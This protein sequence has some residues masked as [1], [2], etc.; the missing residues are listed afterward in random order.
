MSLFGGNQENLF[1]SK[2]GKGPRLPQPRQVVNL[3]TTGD[4]SH[5]GT[6]IRNAEEAAG[7]LSFL[8]RKGAEEAT[9]SGRRER[10]RDCG[11]DRRHVVFPGARV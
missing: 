3:E 7:L 10:R 6:K 1:A 11:F 9:G 8:L 5:Y 4:I 2:A